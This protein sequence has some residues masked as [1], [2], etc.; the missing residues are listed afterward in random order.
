MTARFPKRIAQ[1]FEHFPNIR[2]DRS[3]VSGAPCVASRR[4]PVWILA[5][6]FAAG[7]TI[8][9]IAEDHELEA[10]DV[11]DAI[12]FTCWLSRLGD[13]AWWKFHRQ[14]GDNMNVKH[15]GKPAPPRKPQP[16]KPPNL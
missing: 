11:L 9:F 12:R 15:H 16:K 10:N 7:E 3:I 2:S 6:R 8:E 5:G 14:K 13:I 1:A 4:I